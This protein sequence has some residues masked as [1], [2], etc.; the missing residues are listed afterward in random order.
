MHYRAGELSQVGQVILLLG[1]P[2]G[3]TLNKASVKG[4]WSVKIV[5]SLPFRKTGSAGE[6]SREGEAPCRWNPQCTQR[7]PQP[8]R[9]EHQD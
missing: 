2:R 8:D 6:K 1:R 5:N 4:L 7:R 3:E 9:S